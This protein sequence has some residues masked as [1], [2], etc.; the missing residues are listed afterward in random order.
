[1]A[2]EQ[3]LKRLGRKRAAVAVLTPITFMRVSQSVRM[4]DPHSCPFELTSIDHDG[5]EK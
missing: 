2:K 1:M 4:S 3:K 5:M